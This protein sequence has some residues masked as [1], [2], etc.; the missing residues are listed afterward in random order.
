MHEAV[1][2]PALLHLDQAHDVSSGEQALLCR[3]R[4]AGVGTEAREEGSVE[5]NE[6]EPVQQVDGNDVRVRRLG[7]IGRGD[8]DVAWESVIPADA[9]R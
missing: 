5:L 2:L 8:L 4:L 9:P 6:G 7:R 1:P 3:A